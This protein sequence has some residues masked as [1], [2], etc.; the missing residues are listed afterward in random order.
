MRR[1]FRPLM[2]STRGFLSTCVALAALF[3]ALTS[4]GANAEDIRNHFDSDS[5]LR[6]PGYFDLIELGT[7][8]GKSRWLVLTDLNPPS[9]PNRLVQ[10]ETK[11]PDDALTAA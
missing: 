8:G 4:A 6:P 7:P 5:I 2:K 3:S 11:L 9:A 10:T 1:V